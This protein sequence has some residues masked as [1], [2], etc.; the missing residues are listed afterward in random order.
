MNATADNRPNSHVGEDGR[1]RYVIV[2]RGFSGV[3]NHVTLRKTDAGRARIEDCQVLHVGYEDPWAYYFEHLMGQYP[4]LLALPGFSR[5]LEKENCDSALLSTRFA[6]ETAYEFERLQDQFRS[7]VPEPRSC[8]VAVI[9]PKGGKS[10]PRMLKKLENDLRN[11]SSGAT[12]RFNASLFDPYPVN[13]AA[14]RLLVVEPE[15]GEFTTSWLY[16]DKVDICVGCGVPKLVWKDR[17]EE[18][19]W[20]EYARPVWERPETYPRSRFMIS[21]QHAMYRCNCPTKSR[22]SRVCVFGWGGIGLNLVETRLTWGPV[23]WLDTVE[24]QPWPG[25]NSRNNGLFDREHLSV[26]R[27]VP[28]DS[29]LRIGEGLDVAQV[30][31][32]GTIFHPAGANGATIRNSDNEAQPFPVKTLIPSLSDDPPDDSE[33]YYQLLVAR[34][35][36]TEMVPGTA[37]F[38]TRLLGTLDLQTTYDD[39]LI[40]FTTPDRSV[41]VLGSAA[42]T[43]RKYKQWGEA[44][45]ATDNYFRHLPSQARIGGAG[46]I[47][48]ITYCAL[49]IACANDLFNETTI[50]A[51]V[52]TASFMDL[53]RLLGDAVLAKNIYEERAKTEFGFRTPEE[54]ISVLSS[55]GVPSSPA[56]KLLEFA[57]PL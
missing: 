4:Y 42:L 39:R 24:L 23:D 35:L 30:S 41:R 14:Y 25:P 7:T 11:A 8:W 3:L 56:L 34:G 57:Y 55:V 26:N 31:V 22:A 15:R 27:I 54:L 47:T 5:S 51:N 36:L 38:M 44:S 16:A 10:E 33:G 49:A 43:L 29:R 45:E 37:A 50:N 46:G 1:G 13:N 20:A 19:L 21:G 9:Q 18:P 53:E 2:G 32:D 28:K 48:G 52:N 40:A 17:V 6:A 12:L